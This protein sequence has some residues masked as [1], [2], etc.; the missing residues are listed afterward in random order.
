MRND[1]DI[2]GLEL[3]P[4]AAG[5]IENK[6]ASPSLGEFPGKGIYLTLLCQSA[7]PAAPHGAAD[8]LDFFRSEPAAQRLLD[9][10]HRLISQQNMMQVTHSRRKHTWTNR[11]RRNRITEKAASQKGSFS[12]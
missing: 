12:K 4:G 1:S 6:A 2:A 10:R 7:N 9:Y 3:T 11:P 8:S 5:G